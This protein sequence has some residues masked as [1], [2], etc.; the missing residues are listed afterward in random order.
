LWVLDI[1]FKKHCSGA[2][3]PYRHVGSVVW[4]SHHNDDKASRHT[5][6][7]R[8]V[9]QWTTTNR[10]R[11][12]AWSCRPPPSWPVVA[13]SYRHGTRPKFQTATSC[14]PAA[15]Y[16]ASVSAVPCSRPQ[17]PHASPIRPTRR[18]SYSRRIPSWC[19]RNGLPVSPF[20]SS[21]GCSSKAEY[22]PG[23]WWFSCL[24]CVCVLALG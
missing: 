9:L 17:R 24:V 13:R 11:P 20:P 16:G 12:Q 8:Q 6:T 7:I 2:I 3:S 15:S 4:L 22:R 10:Q 14:M 5:P 18:A 1:E 21:A 19:G 23:E